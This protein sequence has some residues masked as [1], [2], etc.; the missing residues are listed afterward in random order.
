MTGTER[1]ALRLALGVLRLAVLLH[2][3]TDYAYTSISNA[4]LAAWAIGRNP[5]TA[6]AC[7]AAELAARAHDQRRV[8]ARLALYLR[9]VLRADAGD[10]GLWWVRRLNSWLYPPDYEERSAHWYAQG[11]ETYRLAR[12]LWL[13]APRSKP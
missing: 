5:V 8:R 6:A 12:P 7:C 10:R 2:P 4:D 13:D 9:A 11:R 3:R 1:A